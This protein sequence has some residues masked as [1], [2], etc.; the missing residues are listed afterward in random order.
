MTYTSLGDGTPS[1][2]NWTLTGLSLPGRSP[3]AALQPQRE[4]EKE[5]D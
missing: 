2:S 5:H 3:N 4:A 1:G